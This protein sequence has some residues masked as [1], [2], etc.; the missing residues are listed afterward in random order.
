VKQ[1]EPVVRIVIA[2]PSAIEAGDVFDTIHALKRL[3]SDVELEIV[4]DAGSC[5]ALCRQG[6]VDLVVA[7]HALAVHCERIL[8][9][10]R[11]DG[12]PVVVVNREESDEV[13]L[14]MFRRG[15]ADC[16]TLRPNAVEALPVVALEQIRRFRAAR[17]RGAAERR[18]RDL[19]RYTENI[20]QNMNSALLV[21]DMDGRITFCNPPA[22]RILGEDASALRGRA[23]WDWFGDGSGKGSLLATTISEGVS[24]KGAERII[25]RTDGT[26]VPIGIS[27]SPFFDSAGVK[28]GA[29]AIFQDLTEV[30][31]LQSQ[32]LQTEKMASIGQLAAG[33]AHEINNP[34]GFIHANLFQ[35]AEYLTDLRRVWD[36]VDDLHREIEGADIEGVRR[37][38]RELTDLS[39]E[40][41]VS[42]LLSDLG[43]AIR[44]SQEGSERIRHIVHDL[45]DFSHHDTGE[46]VL[47]DVNQCLDST[48]TIVWP[49]MR[50]IVV[51]EK[52]YDH[53]QAILC[54]PMQIKQVFMNLLV[55]AYQ[56]IEAC[57][58]ESGETGKIWLRTRQ[59]H[60]GVVVEVS[61]TGIGIPET[62]IDRIFDPFFTTKKVGSGT[63]LGLSTSFNIVKRH[64][65]AITVESKVGE[66]TTFGV[67]LPADGVGSARDG[68]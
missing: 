40:L 26:P 65:G 43:K 42:Y 24:F 10:L 8:K 64:G 5:I 59:R 67:F 18:I 31:Q 46:R 38:G 54:Y 19:E 25:T 61:D 37:A 33:V 11:N 6:A 17:E 16:V 60:H 62:H 13:A 9:E 53:L 39:N 63:G 52:E 22:G 58:G 35:M 15:A 66:G 2:Q 34:M 56:S 41:D 7:D 47:A 28:I 36:R 21:V 27:C 30:K 44:E 29:V 14:D 68:R 50:Q 23:V 51:L 1:A 57:V 48:A 3:G 4:R 45:R 20:I 12:P 55:N 49:M 32:V